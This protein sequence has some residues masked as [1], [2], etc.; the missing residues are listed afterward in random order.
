MNG[1]P[2]LPGECMTVRAV[3]RELINGGHYMLSADFYHAFLQCTPLSSRPPT[4][5]KPQVAVE[6][7]SSFLVL[8]FGRAAI[9]P[10]AL[11]RHLHLCFRIACNRHSRISIRNNV[12]QHGLQ[13]VNDHQ[14]PRGAKEPLINVVAR[15]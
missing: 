12:P 13:Q 15:L 4:I 6:G 10:D 5:R 7:S 11:P 3:K 2:E 1:E 8:G 14:R 9:A